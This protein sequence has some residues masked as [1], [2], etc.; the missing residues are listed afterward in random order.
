MSPEQKRKFN[1]LFGSLFLASGIIAWGLSAYYAVT[2]NDPQPTPVIGAKHIDLQSCAT[3]LRSLG[4]PEVSVQKNDVIAHEALSA[5]P[6]G[7]LEMKYFCIGES[8]PQ[9][10]ITIVTTAPNNQTPPAQLEKES[11][12]AGASATDPSKPK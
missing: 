10:G 6:Q 9:P 7:Q 12:Q 1:T 4:Y 3:T 2:P 11:A 8:C 5:D